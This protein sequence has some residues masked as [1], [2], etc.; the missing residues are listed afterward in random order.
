M[1]KRTFKAVSRLLTEAGLDIT[2]RRYDR[3]AFGSWFIEMETDPSL[4]V[5]WDGKDGWLI[6]QEK[7]D[8]IFNDQPVW[9]EIDVVKDTNAQTP[10][11][12]ISLVIKALSEME[13]SPLTLERLPQHES[14][15]RM[16]ADA[17]G[18]EYKSYRSLEEARPDSD[19][20]AILE[21]DDGGQ[22]YAVI[23]VQEIQCSVDT[24]ERLLSDLDEISWPGNDPNS[25]RIYLEHQ[26]LGSGIAGGM[27]GAASAGEVWMHEQF[28][29]MG[30]A[31]DIQ[32]VIAGDI[33]HI[34]TRGT[35]D[36]P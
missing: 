1:N 3:Q 22:I 24:L 5:V 33:D 6:V 9:K 26:P 25:K 34:R 30:L 14:F 7:T 10:E 16:V 27:G 15:R 20:V 21:G 2:E 28:R 8:E 11:T 12:A 32:K 36:L 29:K 17:R 13:T 19:A 31:D 35:R 23:P 4:R 18:P